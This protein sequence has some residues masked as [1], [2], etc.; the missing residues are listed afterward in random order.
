MTAELILP[1]LIPGDERRVR[2]LRENE[3][4]V[5]D[6]I[7]VEPARGAKIRLIFFQI[8]R[9]KQ[10]LYSSLNLLC[11]YL[12]LFFDRCFSA[13]GS[14]FQTKSSLRTMLRSCGGCFLI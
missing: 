3:H 2:A 5:I 12:D 11:Q 13:I 4:L 9:L 1:F 6:G 14:P 7:P 10:C 8:T